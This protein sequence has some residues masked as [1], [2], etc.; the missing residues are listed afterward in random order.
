MIVLEGVV[1]KKG[2]VRDLKIIKGENDPMTPNVVA[3]VKQWRFRPATLHG[4]PVDVIY[5]VSSFIHVR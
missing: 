2:T 4:E 1:T 3:A 5:N